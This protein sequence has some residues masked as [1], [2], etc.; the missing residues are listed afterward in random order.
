LSLANCNSAHDSSGFPVWLPFFDAQ[1]GGGSRGLEPLRFKLGSIKGSKK[2]GFGPYATPPKRL[3]I[4]EFL[5]RD[6][7]VGGSN[8]LAPTTSLESATY[9]TRKSEERLVPDQ[10]VDASNPSVTTVL[11][12]LRSMHYVAF[13]TASSSFILR[14]TR[15]TAVV[16]FAIIEFLVDMLTLSETRVGSEISSKVAYAH[17]LEPRFLLVSGTFP[18]TP[19]YVQ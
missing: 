4:F 18:S 17:A 16:L 2:S 15:T 19:L 8:P 6:Q 3:R 7:E 11:S 12:L 14:T 5:V 13:S 1:S 10:D 9:S